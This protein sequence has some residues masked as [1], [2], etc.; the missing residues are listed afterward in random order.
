M[1][2]RAIS[3]RASPRASPRLRRPPYRGARMRA[4]HAFGL[5]PR[6]QEDNRLRELVRVHGMKRWALIASELGGRIGK[7]CR[8][9]WTNHLA[10]DISKEPWTEEEEATLLCAIERYDK[11]WATI[12]KLLPGRTENAVKNHWN[13][14]QRR[15]ERSMRKSGASR[16]T[17]RSGGR[18]RAARRACH[19]ARKL[20]ARW[21]GARAADHARANR[22]LHPPAH[23]RAA[24]RNPVAPSSRAPSRSR[25][26][27][28][29][30]RAQRTQPHPESHLP[31]RHRARRSGAR[32]R[33]RRRWCPSPASRTS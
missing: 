2:A 31:A 27:R 18:A 16:A 19:A 13:A 12:A 24:Q 7:Q 20:P 10:D 25:A 21:R 9:R 28:L 14:S 8:E 33:G 3:R 26:A 4:I 29:I 32:P 17:M 23:A 22:L 11:K 1:L 5:P 6:P 30:R 15:T